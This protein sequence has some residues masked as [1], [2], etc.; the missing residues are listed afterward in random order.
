MKIRKNKGFTLIELM[1]VIA[2]I[3]ILAAIA[4]PAY[5][6]YTGRAQA[7]EGL[8]LTSGLRDDIA[9]IAADINAFPDAGMVATTGLLGS[10]A[11]RLQ[12]KYVPAGGVSVAANT[13]EITVR[14][15]S[16]VVS[17]RTLV[18][19]PTL[20]VTNRTQLIHWTCGGTLGD[21]YLPTSC[22]Q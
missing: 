14:F 12:G 6:Q 8:K 16:G 2:I 22:R 21:E 1:I 11:N 19:T 9:A 15:D 18:M 10:A 17:G 5:S 13:G 7:S 20:N 3:G 4:L